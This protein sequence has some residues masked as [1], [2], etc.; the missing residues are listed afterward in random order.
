MESPS[1]RPR[2][3]HRTDVTKD[4]KLHVLTQCIYNA[5][6]IYIILLYCFQML[7]LSVRFDAGRNA[8]ASTAERLSTDG[9]SSADCLQFPPAYSVLD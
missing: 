2:K 4:K 3:R 1:E 7:S 8:D 9:Q 5:L 6:Y